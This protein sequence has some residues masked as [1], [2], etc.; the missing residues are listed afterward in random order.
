MQNPD[1]DAVTPADTHSP[2]LRQELQRTA[3]QRDLYFKELTKTNQRFEEKVRELSV[4]RR[5]GESLKYTREVRKVFEV[6]ID[7]IIDET[8][9]ENC[10]L[11][12]LN[13]ESSE[14]TVKAARGQMDQEISYYHTATGS[15][16]FK[17]GEGIAG[18]V[19]QHGEPISIPD[20]ST[21]EVVRLFPELDERG[22]PV[23]IPDL[24]EVPQFVSG[25]P[26]LRM[27][28]MMC[29][30]LVI[31][32]EVVGVVNMSHPRPNAFQ[33]EDQQLM[34]IVTDQVTIALNNVQ[35]F[36]DMQQ[37]NFVLEDEVGKATAELRRANDDLQFA[38]HEIQAASQMK[39]QFLAH[40]SHEL[41]TPLNAIIGFSEILEDQTFGPMNE[42]QARYMQNILKS[43]RHL[44]AL[45]NDILDLTKVEAA[46]MELIATDFLLQ[47]LVRN[48]LDGLDPLAKN[49]QIQ[50]TH[51]LAEDF[52]IIEADEGRLRQ[53][54][55]NL[56]SN[57]IKF[58]SEGGLV[59]VLVDLVEDDF[60]RVQVR[61]TGI[62]IKKEHQDLI[63][64]EFSQVD[65]TY[66]RRYMG[67]GLGLALTKRL[68]EMHGG[69]IWVESVEGEGSTFSFTVPRR[70]D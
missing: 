1:A 38:N 8:N 22:E 51:E 44:L 43:S 15:R 52:P 61:D 7:T 4:V 70:Q 62:G 25:G 31:D 54:L 32:N 5:I 56:L 28:C 29:L 18:W 67:T 68:V 39:S 9:A 65:E 2:E 64:S 16:Q 19:A 63:F 69:T 26:G 53:V 47:D 35:I 46:K 58:T 11:M 10:S 45:I 12:L 21:G 59:S 49:K 50:V 13:K 60:V 34:T 55:I 30:P 36:D 20:S 42:R 37:L 27:G 48:V 6:I 17:L 57:A 41:R 66:A 14:L 3:A 33:P 40:M 24:P 23:L